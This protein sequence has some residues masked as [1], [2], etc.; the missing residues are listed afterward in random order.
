ML[1]TWKGGLGGHR[2]G[3]RLRAGAF[4]RGRHWGGG[5]EAG[6]LAGVDV[7]QLAGD[8]GSGGARRSHLPWEFEAGASDQRQSRQHHLPRQPREDALPREAGYGDLRYSPVGLAPWPRALREGSKGQAFPAPG[9]EGLS[10]GGASDRAT[11]APVVRQESPPTGEIIWRL[12]S[13]GQ[14][15][16]AGAPTA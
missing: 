5:F 11:L 7:C 2:W 9:E 1:A 10:T 15:V 3:G 13:G 6:D 4:D 14:W 16:W 12:W 8:L